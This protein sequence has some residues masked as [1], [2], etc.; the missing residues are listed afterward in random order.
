MLHLLVLLN[1]RASLKQVNASLAEITSQLRDLG[2]GK[3]ISS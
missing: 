1:R 2:P 3:G